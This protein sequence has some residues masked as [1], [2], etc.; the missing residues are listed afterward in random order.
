VKAVLCPVCNGVGQVSA[1]FYDR[2]GDWPHWVSSGITPEICRS[3]DGKGWVEVHMSGLEESCN[4][5]PV[6]LPEL[7]PGWQP[8]EAWPDPALPNITG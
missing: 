5:C 8:L 6:T 2:G 1:G 4:P 3:C 7:Y